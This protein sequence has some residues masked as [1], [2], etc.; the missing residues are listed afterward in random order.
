MTKGTRVVVVRGVKVP[1][2]TTG[3][4]FWTGVTKYGPRVG[5]KDSEGTVHW[6]A[7]SNVEAMA[8]APFKAPVEADEPTPGVSPALDAKVAALEARVAALEAA[9]A[10]KAPEAGLAG[11]KAGYPG[12]FGVTAPFIPDDTDPL[13]VKAFTA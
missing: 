11:L 3:E 12:L 4:I 1:R 9:L 7:A 13:T 8:P 2:G 5:F 10:A 6:T